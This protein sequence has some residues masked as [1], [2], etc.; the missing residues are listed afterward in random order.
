MK[1]AQEEVFGPVMVVMKFKTDDEAVNLVN[2]SPFGLG[3]SV[4][5][6]DTNRAER[7]L[8]RMK[9]GMG[10]VCIA[11]NSNSWF[12]N[13]TQELI[14][15]HPRSNRSTTLPSTISLN[16]YLLVASVCPD[17]TALQG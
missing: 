13:S 9:T 7:I 11:L 12:S 17:L 3:G 8:R 4:F 15:T 1:I 16:P 6:L 14:K 5:S 2:S 10:N